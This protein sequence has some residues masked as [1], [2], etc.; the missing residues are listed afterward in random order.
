MV[1]INI[2]GYLDW[3]FEEQLEQPVITETSPQQPVINLE[4][5]AIGPL[6]ITI[7]IYTTNRLLFEITPHQ[8]AKRLAIPPRLEDLL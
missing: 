1:I 3:D 4:H 8:E 2:F 7:E 5:Q 6:P